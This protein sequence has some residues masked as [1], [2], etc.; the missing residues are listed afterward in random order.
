MCDCVCV[1][2]PQGA[3]SCQRGAGGLLCGGA[4][5]GQGPCPPAC[6]AVSLLLQEETQ[7]Q[8]AEWGSS[9]C[10][11]V[12]CVCGHVEA[13][14]MLGSR[15]RCSYLGFKPLAAEREERQ[16]HMLIG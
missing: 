5:S 16:T 15:K 10:V 6:L 13:Q 4:G 1:L 2:V 7:H 11:C 9:E 8:T 12:L 3:P 14:C